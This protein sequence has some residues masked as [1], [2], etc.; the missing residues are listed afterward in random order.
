MARKSKAV[1]RTISRSLHSKSCSDDE[2]SSHNPAAESSS[3]DQTTTHNTTSH[4]EDSH[5]SL[6]SIKNKMSKKESQDVFR[7]KVLVFLVLILAA[8]SVSFVV[9]RLTD[10]GEAEE[11]EVQYATASAK[12]LASFEDI[13]H[14]MGSVSTIGVAFTSHGIHSGEKWPF[15][16]LPDFDQR[17]GAARHMSGA[18]FV[19]FSPVVTRENFEAWDEYVNS[20]A[21][22]WIDEM[23]E[24]Q[25]LL[26]V[27]GYQSKEMYHKTRVTD[28]KV[29]LMHRFDVNGR[30][31]RES[32]P[33]GPYYPM[34]QTSPYVNMSG[35]INHNI[36][37]RPNVSA[38]VKSIMT[39]RSA[40]FGGI[41]TAEP[42]TYSDLHT[43]TALLAALHCIEEG[44]EM[45]YHGE[46]FVE[47]YLPVFDSFDESE[48]EVIGILAAYIQWEYFLETVITNED[49][50]QVVVDYE[51]GAES[52]LVA[53]TDLNGVDSAFTYM[54]HDGHAEL[55][56]YGDV[57]HG[58]DAWMRHGF[59]ITD[60]LD[61]GTVSGVDVD[62]T[63]A[64]DIHVYPSQ[65]FYDHYRT[66]LPAVI[67]ASIA[68]VFIF[69]ISVFMFYDYLVERRQEVVLTKATQSTAIVSSLFPKNVRDRLLEIDNGSGHMGLATKTRIQG[70]L[71]GEEGEDVATAAPIAD[72]FPNC[73]VFF[74][75][76][77]GFTAW[78]STREPAEVFILLQSIFQKFD[79]LAKRRRV[80]KV[81]T[82]GDCCEFVN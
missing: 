44:R 10:S 65:K 56:G 82:I 17:V 48:R 26:G 50:V 1:E 58:F 24:Y 68:A 64:Y 3:E 74:A 71:N 36:V 52:N 33:D 62:P 45:T 39:T 13:V 75:D 67:T 2:D 78:S 20:D 14:K 61:D 60:N 35:L 37:Y 73:S 41:L 12:V 57:H 42:G 40:H 18:F 70:F 46:P 76:I 47:L 4:Q 15:A 6:T 19:G 54:L 38:L 63:C 72:L 29:D 59:L 77:S 28:R 11:F 30:A 81:E 49:S 79:N 5:D 25:E 34:W 51:C 32:S 7:L 22:L 27:N 23:V 21:N 80:F 53:D 16:T 43:R 9:Y 69:T 8:A 66:N 31:V 55:M